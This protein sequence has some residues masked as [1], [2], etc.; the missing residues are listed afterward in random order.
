MS[1]TKINLDI[2]WNNEYSKGKAKLLKENND[3]IW[4]CTIQEI[5]EIEYSPLGFDGLDRI[6]T[7][8]V[9]SLHICLPD[10]TD[11]FIIEES[12]RD[13]YCVFMVLHPNGFDFSF[14]FHEK[15]FIN[16][17]FKKKNK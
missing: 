16:S 3:E 5:K 7:S 12:G 11:V 4:L 1:E 15:S 14:N 6:G 9:E 2:S 17:Y 13:D 8:L 10:K